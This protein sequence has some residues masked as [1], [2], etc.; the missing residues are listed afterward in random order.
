MNPAN[1][2]HIVEADANPVNLECDYHVSFD[3][4]RTWTGG[5]LTIAD[6]GEIPPFPSPACSQNFDS[7]GYAHFNTGIVFGSGQNVYITF[8]AHRG[9]FNRP[10]CGT[11][12]GDGDDAVVARS[13]DGGR[14]FAPAVR[15]ISGGGPVAASPYLAGRA[16]RPQLAV[17][18]GAGDRRPG[19]PLRR[20]VGLPHQDPREPGRPRRVLGRRRRPPDLGRA[21][22][23]R[24]GHVVEPGAGERGERPQ[25][26]GRGTEQGPAGNRR[27]RRGG[28]HR[29]AGPR[30]LAARRR[31]R[32]RGLRGVPQPRHHRRDDLSGESGDHDPRARRVLRRQRRTA[33]SSRGPPTRA[34]RGR[35]SARASRSRPRRSPTRAWRSIRRRRPASGRCT[36]STSARPG[37][38]VGHQPAELDRR[39]PD[40][41]G[42]RARSTTIRPA[43]SRPTRT[44]SSAARRPRRASS[45]ATAVTPYPGDATSATPTTRD[46]PRRARP[47][48]ANRRIT[49]RTFNIDVGSAHELGSELTPGFSWYGPVAL[50]AAGRRA[51][52]GVDGLARGQRR[53][54]V[55]GHLSLA[56]RSGGIDR[57]AQHRH[58]DR[59]PGSR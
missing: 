11:D 25:R 35:S 20:G 1:P 29:R 12:G 31:S 58:G 45:G 15:A 34:R 49:D 57:P 44:S 14:T 39:R 16:M 33:S 32:R 40:L 13:T 38:S 17:Q 52:R 55:P 22:R 10:E 18:R 21:L 46:S 36:S 47:I 56:P 24:R 51:A 5:H 54:R 26:H 50:S 37:R 9:P 4:G 3:G 53:Q 43:S 27:H 8:S 2:D 42:C 19:P 7:G 59:R 48:V 30:A 23:R 6:N 28:Q 41:V